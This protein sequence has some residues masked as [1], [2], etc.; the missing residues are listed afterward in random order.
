MLL[1]QEVAAVIQEIR[2]EPG[3]HNDPRL[4]R[5]ARLHARLIRQTMKTGLTAP[6]PS[7]CMR[8]RRLL[9]E[10]KQETASC[11]LLIAGKRTLCSLLRNRWNCLSGGG[12]SRI[13]VDTFGLVHGDSPGLHYGCADVADF[14]HRMRFSG[15]IRHFSVGQGCLKMTEVEGTKVSSNQTLWPMCCPLPLG[16]SWSLHFAQSAN[17]TR[18]NRQ[19]S[20]HRG[21]EMTYRGPPLVLGGRGQIAQTGH[22]MY[23]DDIGIVSDRV[24]QVHM[25]F[26]ESRQDFKKSRLVLDQISVRSGSGRALGF[27]LDVEQSRT[28]WSHPSR[29]PM[30]FESQTCRWMGTGRPDGPCDLFGPPQTEDPFAFPLCPPVRSQDLPSTGTSLDQ[31]SCRA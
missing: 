7:T 18:L 6:H 5:C 2:G 14:F 15:E 31:C 16:F 26:N 3:R 10:E 20:L 4:L 19:P 12:L 21:V 27:E 8:A 30:F 13:E 11:S 25:V 29:A 9:R 1:P 28:F 22:Y 24:T 17:R 23:V